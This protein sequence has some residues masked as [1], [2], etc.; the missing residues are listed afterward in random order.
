MGRTIRRAMTA[1]VA[2]AWLGT[3]PVQADTL[4]VGVPAVTGYTY[5]AT[6]VAL[7][8]GFFKAHQVDVDVSAFEGGAKLQ[9]AI[10]GGSIDVAVA[11]GT[12]FAFIAKGVPEIAV[13][14]MAGPP[15]ALGVIVPYDSPMKSADDLKGRKIGVTT[16]GSLSEWLMR[17]LAK[18][19][20]WG[21]NGL[22]TVALGNSAR[23]GLA[24]LSTGEIDALFTQSAVGLQLELSK[25]DRLLFPTSDIVQ[26]FLVY[27]IYATTKTVQD[28][29]D[30]LRRFLKG[31]F[32]NIADM[33]AHKAKTVE[34]L[35]SFTKFDPEVQSREYDLVMPMFSADG[36]FDR[37]ALDV[38]A[39]SF[40]ETHMLA[41]KP[42]M[43]K[44]YTEAYLP[45][46]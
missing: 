20:G 16:V 27:A 17:R 37:Q 30:V 12:D 44:L 22:K 43:S 25:R 8:H 28:Q 4:R 3:A 23:A 10:L 31:W 15:L 11:G 1:A 2:V 5:L 42:D 35:R 9:Q 14:A 7:Q 38:L 39:D 18:E 34:T 32:E 45:G 19:K 29:P 36:H 24:A 41:T 21:P 40:V 6:E 33:R 13:A 26:K 46:R